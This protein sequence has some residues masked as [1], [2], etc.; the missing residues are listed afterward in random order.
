MKIKVLSS[1]AGDTFSY[2]RGEVVDL[3]VFKEQVGA[4]WE[5]LGEILDD[6]APPA[7]APPKGRRK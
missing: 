6:A 3:D 2:R 5:T 1:L 4:G 7:T